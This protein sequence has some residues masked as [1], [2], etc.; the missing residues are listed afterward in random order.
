MQ[1]DSELLA[2]IT[3][4]GSS[5]ITSSIG[6]GV[7]RQK[8]SRLE[9]DV[10]KHIEDD[11]VEHKEFVSKALFDAVF[12]QVKDDLNELKVSMKEI[13]TLIHEQVKH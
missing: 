3:A 5:I 6:Y 12:L 13:L 7:L 11:K 2:T 8:V 4:V 10:E 1:I 9:V